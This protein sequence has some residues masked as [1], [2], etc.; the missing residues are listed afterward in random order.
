MEEI[1]NKVF[2]EDRFPGLVLGA[3][4]LSDGLLLIDAPFRHE[5]IHAWRTTLSSLGGKPNKIL[6]LSDTHLDRTFGLRGMESLVVGHHSSI[7][8]LQ[9]RLSSARPQE[10]DPGA[11]MIP[12][13]LAINARWMMPDITY[14]DQISIHLDEDPVLITHH[15]GSHLAGSWVRF[16]EAKVLF[17]GDS[18]TTNQPPF[19]AWADL[20]RWIA[21][22]ELLASDEFRGYKII[23]ARQGR[24][25]HQ[26]ISK[27][28]RILT[29]LRR[30]VT[31]LAEAAEP[32]EVIQKTVPTLLK[33][34][35][36]DIEMTDLYRNRLIWGLEKYLQRHYLESSSGG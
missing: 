22:I 35:S 4:K 7:E 19:L 34:F 31:G 12:Y 5:D 13:E 14:T 17:V 18:V 32:L 21:D 26:S 3:I 8:I 20:D 30:L 6:V 27:M 33:Q 25:Y 10:I 9:N 15:P 11:A 36:F 2:L 23:S 24:L 28:G 1:A 16:D 29:E